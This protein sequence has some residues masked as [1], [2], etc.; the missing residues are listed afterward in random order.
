MYM[1]QMLHKLICTIFLTMVAKYKAYL[2]KTKEQLNYLISLK[3]LSLEGT[4]SLQN[5]Y[6][7][8]KWWEQHKLQ[9]SSPVIDILT[10]FAT[11]PNWLLLEH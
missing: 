1:T 2:V 8:I 3:K 9:H 7:K 10:N 11:Q 5:I 6:L 4:I